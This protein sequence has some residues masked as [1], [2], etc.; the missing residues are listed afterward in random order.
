MRGSEAS[1]I[2]NKSIILMKTS[3]V[4]FGTLLIVYYIYVLKCLYFHICL[5]MPFSPSPFPSNSSS[6]CLLNTC[7]VLG[8]ESPAGNK[9]DVVSTCK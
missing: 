5:P 1:E 2:Y 7:H 6:K 3:H 9:T 4:L 8:T